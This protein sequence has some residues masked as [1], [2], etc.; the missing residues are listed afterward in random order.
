MKKLLAALLLLSLFFVSSCSNN[1]HTYKD[2]YDDGYEDGLHNGRYAGYEDG[3]ED[4][5]EAGSENYKE[6]GWWFEEQA[7][8]HAREYSEWHPE[9]A[10]E[11]ID[12]YE[13]GKPVYGSVPT[14]DEYRDAVKSLYYF[15][16]YFYCALYKD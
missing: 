11:V 3:Y 13:N 1:V 15:Y 5:Y 12:A 9:E 10:M 6:H 8:D 7:V 14:L 16:D 2:G 4:G